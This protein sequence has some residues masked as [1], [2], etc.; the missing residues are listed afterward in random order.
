MEKEIQ[1]F[2]ISD[3]NL[4][5]SNPNQESPF[6]EDT[7]IMLKYPVE[8]FGIIMEFTAENNTQK[9]RS[10]LAIWDLGKSMQ[11]SRPD[12]LEKQIE[13]YFQSVQ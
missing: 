9:T 13:N 2:T 10:T 4:W 3:E 5:S 7:R 12:E 8:N 6:A 11:S 1:P